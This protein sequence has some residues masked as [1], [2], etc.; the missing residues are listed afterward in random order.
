VSVITIFWRGKGWVVAVATF[1][2]SLVAEILTRAITHDESYYG[3]SP[4]PLALALLAASGVA[5]GLAY[6]KR[7]EPKKNN[8]LFFVPVVYWAAILLLCAV[9]VVMVRMGG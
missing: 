6:V 7:T 9:L 5:A 3:R 2:C 4:W 1:L 8:S